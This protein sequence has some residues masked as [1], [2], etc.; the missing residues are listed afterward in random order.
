MNRKKLT[1]YD[2]LHTKGNKQLS[3]LFVHNVEEAKAAEEAGID[4]ICTSHDSPDYGI[5]TPFTDLKR[6]REA[7]PSCFM[8]SGGPRLPSSESEAIKLAHEY[9]AIG[10]D[11]IYAGNYSYKFI[12]AMREENIPINGHVGL[13][14]EPKWQT[15]YFSMVKLLKKLLVFLDTLWSFRML[16]S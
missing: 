16:E 8:Q 11:C 6:I 10:A 4:M 5:L 9:M 13:V 3:V 14:I 7:A 1:V 15:L 2:Y 12:K